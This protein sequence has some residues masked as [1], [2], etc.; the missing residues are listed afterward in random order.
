MTIGIHWNNQLSQGE[1]TVTHDGLSRDDGLVT[2]VLICLFTDARAD[3]DD[4]IPD[5]SGD[6]RGWPGDTFSDAP[7]GS[8]LW[9]LDREKLTGSVRQRVED[10]ASLS[11]EPLLRAGYA[12]SATV[13]ATVSGYDRINFIVILTRPDKS[14][15]RIDISK[16]WEATANAL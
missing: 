14:H 8:K 15:L 10:Y 6:P 9:L 2:L 12:R 1:I 4:I 5:G 11:M 7:W 16:R 3:A 13:T